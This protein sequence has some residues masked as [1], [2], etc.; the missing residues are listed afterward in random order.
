MSLSKLLSQCSN[1]KVQVRVRSKT[2]NEIINRNNSLKSIRRFALRSWNGG[3]P[4]VCAFWERF[5]FGYGPHCSYLPIGE[6]YCTRSMNDGRDVQYKTSQGCPNTTC[7]WFCETSNK[8]FL[9]QAHDISSYTRPYLQI[10]L[11]S[12]HVS[13]DP[14]RSALISS[15]TIADPSSVPLIKF[16]YRCYLHW[17]KAIKLTLGR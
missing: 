15:R 16:S 5:W 10:P 11:T 12:I 17:E 9:P 14:D 6:D 13:P 4:H 8:H 1:P 3:Y 2:I 7:F